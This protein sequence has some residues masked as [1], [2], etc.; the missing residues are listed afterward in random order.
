VTDPDARLRALLETY[1]DGELSA[2]ARWRVKR[3]LRRDAG[4]RRV[5]AELEA[6]GARLREIDAE[7]PAPD[8]WEGIRLRLPAL[9]GRR[10]EAQAEAAARRAW[11]RLPGALALGAAACAA[12]LVLVL[13][14]SGEKESPAAP[15]APGPPGSVRW[16]DSRGHPMLVLRDD[17]GGTIIWVPEREI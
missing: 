14:W 6:I 16:I 11:L 12:A 13:A 17:R 1:R 4:A 3:L 5:L 9:D 10:A 2:P 7:A 8:L 15:P